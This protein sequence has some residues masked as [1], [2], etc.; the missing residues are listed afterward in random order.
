MVYR[1][2]VSRVRVSRFRAWPKLEGQ[3]VGCRQDGAGPVGAHALPM[4]GR[5]G[6]AG[7]RVARVRARVSITA[8]A[9][10]RTWPKCERPTC[11]M[12][13]ECHRLCGAAPGPREAG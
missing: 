3:L 6:Q 11:R 13:T 9:R 1:V 12:P 8:R 4:G 10:V 2:M 7:V 5:L